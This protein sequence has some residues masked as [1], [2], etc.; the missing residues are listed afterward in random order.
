[1]PQRDRALLA[2]GRVH[3]LVVLPVLGRDR[4]DAAA[5]LPLL[6][7]VTPMT[8]GD[9]LSVIGCGATGLVLG[10]GVGRLRIAWMGRPFRAVSP[11]IPPIVSVRPPTSTLSNGDS[12]LVG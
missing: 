8:W 6:P 10:Y 9:P 3:R 11:Y 12:D 7:E 1:V 5:A 4:R 2:P